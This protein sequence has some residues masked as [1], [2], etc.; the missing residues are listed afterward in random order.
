[1]LLRS[2]DG[3]RG[4]ACHDSLDERD[5]PDGKS[6]S[7][8]D[9]ARRSSDASTSHVPSSCVRTTNPGNTPST[10]DYAKRTMRRTRTNRR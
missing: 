9:D 7:D 10:K 6:S 4:D 3:L 5:V 8:G 1:M 2:H